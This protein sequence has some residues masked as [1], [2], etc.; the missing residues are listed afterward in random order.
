M[1]LG[2]FEHGIETIRLL[3]EANLGIIIKT[4]QLLLEANL[5]MALKQLNYFKKPFCSKAVPDEVV[6]E[7]QDPL[8]HDHE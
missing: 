6:S 3:S 7:F 4:T 8:M 1:K 2:Q 5:S